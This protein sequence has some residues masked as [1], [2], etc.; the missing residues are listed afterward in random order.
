MTKREIEE[1]FTK[2]EN[3]LHKLAYGYARSYGR[4][5]EEM[6]SHACETFMKVCDTFDSSRGVSIS[7]YLHA[8]V[9]NSLGTYVQK[10]DLPKDTVFVDQPAEGPS[11]RQSL[12]AKEWLADLSDEC[13]MVAMIILNGPAEILDIPKAA[14]P[15][16]VK[17]ALQRHLRKLGWSWPKI[18]ETISE[19]KH[20][21]R[22]FE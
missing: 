15:R 20:A 21:V 18:W 9:R 8:A 16:A 10:N 19:M 13:K 22:T 17:G 4:T 7:T 3:M 1:T 14:T 11:P 2:Y 5:E 6:F 12:I